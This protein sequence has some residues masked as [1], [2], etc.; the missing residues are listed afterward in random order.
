MAK[1]TRYNGNLLAFGINA[2]GT[3]RTVFGALLQSD[4][5]DDNINVEFL[6][7][8]GNVAVDESPTKQDFNGLAFT[9]GQLIAYIHQ[10]G[11]PE[12]HL[13]QEY[14]TGNITQVTGVQYVSQVDNNIGNNPVDDDG[15]NWKISAIDFNHSALTKDISGGIDVVLSKSESKNGYIK[16]TGTLTA[17]VNVI[18]P[19]VEH[20]VNF[21]NQTTGS[22]TVTIKTLAGTGINIPQGKSLNT[23]CDGANVINADNGKATLDINSE[24]NQL[25]VGAAAAAANS[26]LSQDGTWKTIAQLTALLPL[27]G[28][29]QVW[30]DVTASRAFNTEYQNTT[31]KP[32]SVVV[33]VTTGAASTAL[34]E[35]SQTSGSGFVETEAARTSQINNV[36]AIIPDGHYYKVTTSGSVSKNNWAELR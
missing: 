1:V 15:T 31:G 17:S 26:L 19:D 33:N 30:Q 22:F 8:W 2:V 28:D 20:K 27:I 12:F 10:A 4:D 3:E 16:L 32:I 25:P 11:I 9:L 7:G 21:D 34:L 24:V 6:R 5:L 29:A 18:V 23:Y 14:H 36:S 13:S 35:V